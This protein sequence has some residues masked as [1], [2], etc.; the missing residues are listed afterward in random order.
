MLAEYS[1][2]QESESHNRNS[3]ETR[4]NIYLTLVSISF[5]GAWTFW[6]T[7][8]KLS[9][10][11]LRQFYFVSLLISLF[12]FFIGWQTFKLFISRWQL[13]VIYLRKLARI[14]KWF[15][16]LDSSLRSG[17]TYSID[18]TKPSFLSK[19]FF[20]SSLLTLIVVLNCTF[21]AVIALM[22]ILLIIPNLV[23]V[24][25][26]ALICLTVFLVTLFVHY[27]SY[28]KYVLKLEKDEFAAF[29]KPL[30][31]NND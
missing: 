11:E 31:S 19:S 4:F 20:S 21:V 5:A 30:K 28:K 22:I 15:L 7:I 17:L 18:E 1:R 12:L 25:S 23:S 13:T 10:N 26:I 24:I 2:I 6:G 14:R 3:G 9:A 8:D 16:N 29:P 27:Q